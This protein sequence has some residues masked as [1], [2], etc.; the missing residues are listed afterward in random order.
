MARFFAFNLF[1]DKDFPSNRCYVTFLSYEEARLTLEHVASL[2]LVSSGFKTE[3]LHS[4]NI[5]DSDMD[6]IPNIFNNHLENSVPEVRQISPPRWFVAYYRNGRGNFIHVSW[7]LAKEIGTIP[8]GQLKTHVPPFLTVLGSTLPDHAHIGP[9]NL[10]VR[11][12]VSRPLQCFS[13]YRQC[14]RYR[15]EQDILQLANCQ[16]I[17]LSST[18][19]E[20]LYRQ[21]DG[22]GATSCASLAS[23]LSA[24]SAGE[25]IEDCFRDRSAMAAPMVSVQ[26]SVTP[27]FF[28][29]EDA[30]IMESSD[31]IVT[32]VPRGP[33]VAKSAVWPDPCP[34]VPGC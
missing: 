28:F 17:S 3:L 18:R 19:R 13:C 20:L 5:A 27:L 11:R 9:I 8:E 7:Y 10:R 12:F 2:T 16:F 21:K 26:A 23:R 33:T 25:A 31:D 4:S 15:L 30:I 29:Y 6:Y 34:P 1:Y 14:P 24:E 22:T 32:A